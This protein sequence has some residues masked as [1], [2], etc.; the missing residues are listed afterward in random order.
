MKRV[1]AVFLTG[2]L[3][4]ILIPLVHAQIEFTEYEVGDGFSGAFAYPVDMD[5]D[6][7][8]DVI[9]SAS[10]DDDVAWFEND[11]DGNFEE[12]TITDFLDGA[13][14]VFAIDLDED[15]DIDVITAGDLASRIDWWEN[16]GDMD[17]TQNLIRTGLNRPICVHAADVDSDGDMDVLCTAYLNNSIFWYENDGDQEFTEHVIVNNFTAP[18]YVYAHDLDQDDDMDI[19]AAGNTIN[20]VT[21]W[22]NNGEEVFTQRLI[23]TFTGPK[24]LRVFDVNRDGN[25]DVL[26]A[27][28]NTASWF[29]NDGNQLFTE[30]VVADELGANWYD[31]H[32]AD[33]DED[34]DIDIM[35]VAY[36]DDIA[37]WWEN[38]GDEEF[39]EH[40]LSDNIDGALTAHT[41]DIDNDGDLDIV[42]SAYTGGYISWFANSM[43]SP[44][45]EFELL[46]PRNRA[47]IDTSECTFSW[48]ASPNLEI[49]DTIFYELYLDISE[50]F[51]EPQI[52]DT[53][54]DT[55]FTVEN[56]EDDTEYWWKVLASDLAGNTR[57]S[58]D[59]WMLSIYVPQP[60]LP[61]NL[62]SPD[63]GAVV[64]D[65]DVE[66]TWNSSIDPDPDDEVEY[67][68][69]I[70]FDPEEMGTPEER[71]FDDTTYTFNAR[72]QR[73]HYWTVR[74]IDDNTEGTWADQ[75]WSFNIDIPEPP[76]HFSLLAPE[77][78]TVI[79]WAD[80]LLVTTVWL[81]STDPDQGD[82][83]AYNLKITV[84]LNDTSEVN[85][86]YNDLTDTSYTIN[87]PADAE[88]ENWTENIHVVWE[89]EA[90][91]EPDIVPCNRSFEFYL[92]PEVDVDE[93]DESNIP[94]RYE[95]AEL[96]PN[97]FNTSINIKIGLPTESLL[98]LTVYNILGESASVIT[99]DSYP[100]GW[101]GFT[102]DA[103]IL[104]SGI[105]FIH[106]SVPGKMDEVRKVVLIR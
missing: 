102:F 88:I 2:S 30:H 65:Y 17:F 56:L 42:V 74:A 101:Q 31:V 19:L 4:A 94:A 49:G 22:E 61:F 47:E 95:I 93:F 62:I 71:A 97:P 16:D 5:G 99:E 23:A 60:P 67:E 20:S 106:A 46:S 53:G 28:I 52:Y 7:D 10:T 70:S 80:P 98:K 68:L 92:E 18:H 64:T 40:S 13:R 15:D 86:E 75:V 1:I 39:E 100:A 41:V 51:E 34:D 79:P 29:E 45:G 50:D 24:S 89:V 26:A 32:A 43:Y 91:S 73:V 14:F 33:L 38:I 21:W 90:I 105:Y 9:A 55:I 57:W 3:I 37:T 27:G 82:V 36:G 48:E 11:G 59:A 8:I 77:D 25:L 63:S 84:H 104:T 81:S 87:I 66:L 96:F 6:N 12:H 35:T 58:E 44:P 83:V 72:S 103:S 76:E 85:L 69:Y 54:T 78:E